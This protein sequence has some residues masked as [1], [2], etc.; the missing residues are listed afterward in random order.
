MEA[1]DFLY[2]RNARP[3][4]AL[5]GRAQWGTK[6]GRPLE[7]GMSKLGRIICIVER[8]RPR[9]V[10]REWPDALLA[11]RTC[12]MKELEGHPRW[13]CA[14]GT[15]RGWSLMIFCAR[16]S[17]RKGSRVFE[18]ASPAGEAL[19]HGDD[20]GVPGGGWLHRFHR[21]VRHLSLSQF[22]CVSI[23]QELRLLSNMLVPS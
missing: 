4:K 16:G 19:C 13:S 2:S 8:T 17:R 5:V 3:Q 6:P 1:D 11:R 12:T 9:K 15:E 23:S 10:G 20:G 22:G 7:S 14:P 18:S 21:R